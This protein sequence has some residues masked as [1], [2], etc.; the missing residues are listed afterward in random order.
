MEEKLLYSSKGGNKILELGNLVSGGFVSLVGLLILCLK[1]AELF[2]TRAF[3]EDSTS[4]VFV[5]LFGIFMLVFG[6]YA[7]MCGVAS[8]QSY[9]RVYEKHIEAKDFN[10]FAGGQ[11]DI[12]IKYNEIHGVGS[13]GNSMLTLQTTGKPKQIFIPKVNEAKQII[14]QQLNKK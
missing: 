10:L 2:E 3:W 11:A 8:K 9:L 1:A 12:T 13:K 7:F 4:D 5:L 14:L 6:I